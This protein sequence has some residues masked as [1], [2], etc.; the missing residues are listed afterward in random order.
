M[1]PASLTLLSLITLIRRYH[2]EAMQREVQAV[3]MQ[4]KVEAGLSAE[5][6]LDIAA[7][8]WRKAD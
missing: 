2:E 1:Q 4:A 5:W 8:Q 6:G 7:G 3:V